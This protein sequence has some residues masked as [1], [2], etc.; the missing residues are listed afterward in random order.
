MR[1]SLSVLSIAMLAALLTSASLPAQDTSEGVT[2][3]SLAGLKLREIGPAV[4]GGRIADIA[5]DHRDPS[6]WFLAVGSGGVW[7]TRNAGITWAPIFD[8]QPSYS[9]GC[10][11]LDPSNPDTVWVGTGENVSGRHVGW[12]DGVY[13]SRDGGHSWQRMGLENS[14]HIGKI[15]VDPRDSNI[16]L[17]ASEG[18]L[19]S[20]GGE[21][22]LYR[23]E[24]GGKSWN[25]T[26]SIDDDTGVTDIE[27]EPGNPDVVYAASYQRRR[28]VW[29]LLAGGPGSGIHKSTDGGKTWRR[30]TSGLPKGE[31]GKIGLAVTPA[32]P[33][34]VYATIEASSEERGFYRSLNRGESWERRDDY[35]SNGTGPHYYQEIEAS[36]QFADR[37]YQMDVFIHV[38]RDGGASFD[39]LGD[40]RQKHSDNHALWI[41]PEDGDHLIAG[42]DGGLY[43]TFDEG[44]TWRHFGNLPISQFYKLALDNA[45]PFYNV[46]GGAQDLG[47]LLGPSRTTNGEGV[48]NRDW[49]V[50]MGADGYACAFDPEDPDTIYLQWQVG[51]LHRYDRRTEEALDIQ[52]QPGPDDPPERW[53]WDAPVVVSPHSRTRLYHGS[54]RLWKSEDR[55]NS[56]TAV[57]GD[58]TRSHN[59]YELP[60]SGRVRSVDALYDNGAMSWYSTL[61]SISESPLVEGLLYVGSDDGLIHV[62]ENGGEDWRSVDGIEG[63]PD[64]SFVNDLEASP[65]DRDTVFAALDAHKTGDFSPLLFVSTDRG[66]SWSSITGD[67]PTETIVWSVEQDPVDS[68]LIFL[69]TEFGIYVTLDSG[70][71]WVKLT[72]GVPTISFRDIELHT[73]DNDLVGAS[74]GRGFYVLDDYAPLRGVAS[75]AL[76]REAVLFPVRDAWWYIPSVPMQAA[77]KPSQGSSDYT[78]PNPPFGAVLTY[79]LKEKALTSKDE[80]RSEEKDLAEKGDSIAFP[81][82]DRL[83]SEALETGPKVILTILDAGGTAVRRVEGP[84]RAGI[85]RVSWDLRLPAPDPVDL[86]VPGFVPPWARAPRGPLAPPGRYR[87]EMALLTSSGLRSLGQPQEF[88]VKPIPDDSTSIDYEAV[89]DFQSETAELI[90]QIRGAAEEL[91]RTGDR[92]RHMRAA[93]VETPRADAALFTRLGRLEETLDSLRL[94]LLGDRIRGRWNEPSVPSI[95]GRIGQ[96]AGGHWEARQP[97]T[98]TQRNNFELAR[99]GFDA[100]KEEIRALVETAT[101]ELESAL[102]SAGAPWTP[103]RKLPR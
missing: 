92:L 64:L 79:S 49:Y 38:T 71:S 37:V 20:S 3:E 55:G 54:Q 83:R 72:G 30:I 88:Q 1:H 44:T 63:V 24:D 7:K 35:I 43:E 47:T 70:S 80:R 75:G 91:R 4:M 76:G 36:P 34:I 87:V 61:T 67:L 99:S 102:E 103:G 59:R 22:G 9:V 6:T 23:S 39:I 16:V 100:V 56:W 97:P 50:P 28:S 57:S 86:R 95:L 94:R 45:E 52:P 65:H 8:G 48:R 81:G 89:A 98:S 41:D 58:L 18:P 42:T 82:W 17:V 21:R 29:S 32:D 66:R 73:R 78:A 12:G 68:R 96:V 93:L 27:F 40:G 19:W 53:N 51:R 13:K 25:A 101:P 69:G 26:L 5:V 14:Q 10:V 74:F 60:M 62:S 77:G 2:S 90:R 31:M 11:T 46:L 85:H 15:L 33:N 84:A